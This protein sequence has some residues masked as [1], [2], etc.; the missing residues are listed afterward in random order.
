MRKKRESALN[1]IKNPAE[2]YKN[3]FDHAEDA[4]AMVDSTGTIIAINK[5]EEKIIGY[6][7]KLLI[8]KNFANLL[9]KQYKGI[10]FDCLKQTFEGKKPSTEEVRIL[11]KRRGVLAMELDLECIKKGKTVSFAQIHLRD[12]TE[13]K[14][15]EKQI[16]V[17]KEKLETILESM[18]D[19]LDIVDKDHRIQYMNRAFIKLFGNDS[20]GKRCYKVFTHNKKPCEKCPVKID[21]TKTGI[22][23]VASVHGRT[24]LVIHSPFKNLDGTT[25]ILEIFKDITDK[26]KLEEKIQISED[27]YK[28][29]FD[30]AADSVFI[31]DQSGKIVGVNKREE[32]AIG[33]LTNNLIGRKF[34]SLLLKE[35]KTVFK[36]KISNLVKGRV[37]PI[38]EIRLKNSEK[39]LLTMEMEIVGLLE[40]DEFH[41]AQIHL[42]DITKN[43]ELEHQ[44]LKSERLAVLS[45]F[46]SALA[47]DLRN[48]VIGIIKVLCGLKG[49][50]GT[51]DSN[52][53]EEI[54]DEVI[55]S[56]RL[57]L[58]IINDVFDMY[59]N[60]YTGL[61]L[62]I[63]Q[64]SF[65]NAI[66]EVIQLLKHEAEDAGVKI[67]LF[68]DKKDI[69][70]KGDKRRIQRVFIN[71]LVNAIKFSPVNGCVKIILTKI[72]NSSENYLLCKVNDEGLGVPPSDSKRI[73]ELFQKKSREKV[74]DRSGLGLGLY[75]C[76]VVVEAHNGKIWVENNQ[77]RGASFRI[78][79]PLKGH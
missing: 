61:S 58:G 32:E 4:M 52:I 79:F 45:D 18:G 59:Q 51:V 19:G 62:L 25:S 21:M 38:A 46:S 53:T 69:I 66:S 48:P 64:F 71:L 36:E 63:S 9:Q 43:K 29:L 1:Q 74:T 42:R 12:I 35:D 33:F 7:R 49:R 28:T 30:R 8:G 55:T 60:S 14:L 20:I 39:K 2:I 57:L 3:L 34:T 72:K 47:H 31:L 40:K 26:K 56:N 75:F 65:H 6:K 22:L 11:S 27:R 50:I 23:E 37:T 78:K 70:F 76:R 77:D 24:Y 73:F 54:L 17:E 5:R 44:L 16:I 10:F 13:Q 67:K 41:Y 15:L 68:S